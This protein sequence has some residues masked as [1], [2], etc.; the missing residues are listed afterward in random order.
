MM[1][2]TGKLFKAIR[3]NRALTQ[4]E[5]A[6]NLI[7]QS[8][9]S[10]FE[11]G[12]QDISSGIFLELLNRLNLSVDEFQ[13]ISNNYNYGVKNNLI[14]EFFTLNYNNIRKITI[15]E[16]E[17]NSFLEKQYDVEIDDIRRICKAFIQMNDNNLETA[18]QIVEPIWQRI[19]LY[20]QWYVN[21]LKIINSIL[22]LFPI[23]S[24]A[25]FTK[26]VLSRLSEYN[27]YP[28]AKEL[29]SAFTVNLS[30]LLIKGGKFSEALE[31]IEH[32][33]L[34]EKKRLHYTILALYYTRKAICQYSLEVDKP[35]FYLE[36]AANLVSI[37][38]DL[39]YWDCI[40]KEYMYY[41]S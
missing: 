32:S 33:L 29:E 2:N 37:Y 40:Y 24:V 39:E 31:I 11:S 7:S 27:H 21:D 16:K 14:K 41:T 17:I 22:F 6:R 38:D 18:Q 35:L 30:L 25:D 19:S 20:E 15:L 4:V 13:Y 8:T 5:V 36:K 12:S 28:E 23:D 9:Y 10:K 3:K 26:N 1:I 34:V